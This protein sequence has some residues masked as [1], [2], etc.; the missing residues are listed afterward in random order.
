MRKPRYVNINLSSL[1]FM[2]ALCE[3]TN[4]RYI[5]HVGNAISCMI[6][7]LARDILTPGYKLYEVESKWAYMVNS[8]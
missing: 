5:L 4:Y 1:L 2:A 8:A 7:L 6:S 3:Y